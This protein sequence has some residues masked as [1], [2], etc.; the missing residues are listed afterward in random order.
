MTTPDLTTAVKRLRQVQTT[1]VH[2]VY[3]YAINDGRAGLK[4]DLEVALAHVKAPPTLTWTTRTFTG[5]RITH[6]A[7]RGKLEIGFVLQRDDGTV[8]YSATAAVHMGRVAKGHGEVKSIRA[9][10]QAVERA[11]AAWLKAADIG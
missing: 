7:M 11:W 5:D 9:G 1:P 8:V 3:P 4:Q 6:I 10:K 2:V